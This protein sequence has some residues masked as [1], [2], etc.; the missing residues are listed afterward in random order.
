MKEET[1]EVFFSKKE[2][3]KI[4]NENKLQKENRE[5]KSTVVYVI[6]G[7]ALISI[8]ILIGII[9]KKCTQKEST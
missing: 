1:E 5:E 8:L 7:S 9:I 3:I 4:S 2:E 6:G